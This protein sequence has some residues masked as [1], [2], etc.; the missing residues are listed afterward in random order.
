[1]DAGE[2]YMPRYH[3]LESSDGVS[4]PWSVWIRRWQE[5]MTRDR[6]KR[7]GQQNHRTDKST[8]GPVPTTPRPKPPHQPNSLCA[9]SEKLRAD[10]PYAP[11][12]W[13][14]ALLQGVWWELCYLTRI[15]LLDSKR[16]ASSLKQIS[17]FYN[18]FLV[19]GILISVIARYRCES[20]SVPYVQSNDWS[21]SVKMM[22]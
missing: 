1:M 4:F 13:K 10:D 2:W 14:H 8:K 19:S 3:L 7:P 15:G 11:R 21:W 22:V 20:Y 18:A 5:T 9:C 12:P 16:S 17:T 6:T